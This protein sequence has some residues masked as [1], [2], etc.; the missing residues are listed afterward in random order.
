MEVFKK[1]KREATK[2]AK[3]GVSA[4]IIA[5]VLA[6]GILVGVGSATIAAR[7]Y[8]NVAIPSSAPVDSEEPTINN[9][10][11]SD[12][13]DSSD[14]GNMA[15]TKKNYH[16]PE[17][18]QISKPLYESGEEL[19]VYQDYAANHYDSL[20]Y[21]SSSEYSNISI[22]SL[23]FSLYDY[24]QN[25]ICELYMLMTFNADVNMLNN[26]RKNVDLYCLKTLEMNEHGQFD[27]VE[28]SVGLR[29]DS[30]VH[31]NL[32]QEQLGF[33]VI[34][35]ERNYLTLCRV[36]YDDFTSYQI[37]A[38]EGEPENRWYVSTY[39]CSD[40]KI[41]ALYYG[42]KEE[43]LPFRGDEWSAL[44]DHLIKIIGYGP[45]FEGQDLSMSYDEFLSLKSVDDAP[46]PKG[47]SDPLAIYLA[48][49]EPVFQMCREYYSGVERPSN[50]TNSED[51]PFFSYT[52]PYGELD[53]G[54]YP[55]DFGADFN[56]LGYLLQD[57]SG[58]GI[59]ELII[60]GMVSAKDIDQY[61]QDVIY[62]MFTIKNGYPTRVLAS[63][64]R[65]RF[66]LCTDNFV[67]NDG[68]GGA[69]SQS[70]VLYRFDGID[71]EFIYALMM[72]QPYY[73]EVKTERENI[74]QPAEGD[75]ML[76]EGEYRAKYAEMSADVIHLNLTPLP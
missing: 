70:A 47:S 20:T 72:Q 69:F 35:S 57:I 55:I 22:D 29:E 16:P 5:G 38:A 49:Y 65:V 27:S 62:D 58:D 75:T 19:K 64:S 30:V 59:P 26:E 61:F 21:L 12:R 23:R 60:G 1:M 41:K 67:L 7:Y 18:R 39:L 74:W 10:A 2:A 66:R 51:L 40:G 17:M 14:T 33:C 48:A 25:G 15:S 71:K 34:S 11:Y 54:R 76:S 31:P 50:G 43:M 6:M 56:N 9:T 13:I 53:M 52:I 68:S 32:I 24:N 28:S 4:K 44:F 63:S 3:T 46:K 45:V 37:N 73:Y 8:Q 36:P 42:E